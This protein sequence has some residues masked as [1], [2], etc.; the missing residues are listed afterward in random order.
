M[1]SKWQTI[2]NL[3]SE[4]GSATHRTLESA[5]QAVVEAK[6]SLLATSDVIID[7]VVEITASATDST[8]EFAD[9]ASAN[10]KNLADNLVSYVLQ[11]ETSETDASTKTP[12]D[13]ADT[14]NAATKDIEDAINKLQ[15]GDRVGHAG[16]AILAAAG[17]VSGI[18]A[19]GAI[20]SAAGASTL[21]GSTSLAGVLGGVFVTA[22][23]VGWVV[24]AAI[25]GSAAAYGVSKLVRSGGRQDRLRQEISNRLSKRLSELRSKGIQQSALEQLQHSITQAIESGHLSNEQAERMIGLVEN[26]KL[27]PELALSRVKSLL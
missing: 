16:Q 8:L 9:A 14:T 24:G 7:R 22:T 10:A 27:N 2:T 3:A 11:T 1:K 21:L 15:A 4:L 19:S 26:G 5:N 17:G 20:A 12:N 23:P 18:T 25:A 6:E 13:D